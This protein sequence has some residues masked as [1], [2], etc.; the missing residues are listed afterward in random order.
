MCYNGRDPEMAAL[1]AEHLQLISPELA[2][3]SA[4]FAGIVFEAISKDLTPHL[5]VLVM[6]TTMHEAL[7]SHNYGVLVAHKLIRTPLSV[8][9]RD[10]IRYRTPLIAKLH[11]AVLSFNMSQLTVSRLKQALEKENLC[12]LFLC[13]CGVV[14]GNCDQVREFY[15]SAEHRDMDRLRSAI[16]A[17]GNP[18]AEV[19]SWD[20]IPYPNMD[21]SSGERR[22]FE[23]M[24]QLLAIASQA[25]PGNLDWIDASLNNYIK[26]ANM[27]IPA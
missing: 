8:I 24:A 26:K 10:K 2:P 23:R 6:L 22:M 5:P 17:Q 7:M 13:S 11:E 21:I 4:R 3:A 15:G 18:V 9:P 1:N 20:E 19:S 12:L 14:L 25:G 27:P 16:D